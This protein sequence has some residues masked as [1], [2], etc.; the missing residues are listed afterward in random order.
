MGYRSG[1][2]GVRDNRVSDVVSAPVESSPGSTLCL[3][4]TTDASRPARDGVALA[5]GVHAAV[6]PHHCSP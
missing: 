1:G 2:V 4:P 3:V 5:R 6:D